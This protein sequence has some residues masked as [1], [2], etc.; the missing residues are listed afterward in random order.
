VTLE[1]GA[2]CRYEGDR[3]SWGHAVIAGTED[4]QV[5]IALDHVGEVTVPVGDVTVQAFLDLTDEAQSQ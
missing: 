4:G 3:Y 5:V 1:T 2:H